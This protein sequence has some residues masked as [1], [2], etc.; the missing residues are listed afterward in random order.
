VVI[1][2]LVWFHHLVSHPSLAS[3]TSAHHA[4]VIL[5]LGTTLGVIVQ[6]VLLVPSLIRAG[7]HLRLIWN[8]RHEA[9]RRI[10]RLAGWTFGWVVA[11]QVA[12]VVVLAL[13]DG[14]REAGAVTAYTYAYTFFQLPYG[15]VAVSVMTA[16]TPSLAA[17]WTRIDLRGFRRRMGIGLRGML[18]IVVPS[19]AGML[20]LARP[21]ID[22]ILLHVNESATSADAISG[23]LAMFA[24]GLPGFCTFL[25]AVRVFQAMQDTR[26]AFKLYLVENAINVVLAVALVGPLGVRGLALALSIAYTV[27]A[28]LALGVIRE[29]VGGLG[30]S[31]LADP[32][33]RIV[34]GSLV[35]AVVAGLVVNLSGSESAVVLLGRIVLA[36]VV[37]GVAYVGTVGLMGAR[38]ERRRPPGPADGSRTAPAPPPAPPP[39]P[40]PADDRPVPSIHDRLG[41]RPPYRH[42]RPVPGPPDDPDEEDGHGPHPGGDGQRL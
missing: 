26:T 21:L 6:A 32:L 36:M 24:L 41:D 28:A 42:L 31:A 20:V 1:A 2:V 15:V 25:Y 17:R 14:A 30:G 37:G 35:L 40:G 13:A 10:L 12:L 38:A 39:A 8:P 3:V 33:R 23:A 29:R 34:A 4:L 11:N 22:L 5:G 18:A 16:V 19:A 7:P 9:M 27:S